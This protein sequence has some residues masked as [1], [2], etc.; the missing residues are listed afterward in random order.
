[1]NKKSLGS[2]FVQGFERRFYHGLIDK[3]E[4]ATLKNSKPI[5]FFPAFLSLFLV[6]SWFSVLS[7]DNTFTPSGGPS[8]N[9]IPLGVTS[10][11]LPA[12]TLSVH[13]SLL[14]E[15]NE[16]DYHSLFLLCIVAL[17]VLITSYLLIYFSV[18][19]LFGQNAGLLGSTL[20]HLTPSVQV[21]YW[22]SATFDFFPKVHLTGIFM[23]LV[24]SINA[25]RNP[26]KFSSV[27]QTFSES[28][29]IWHLCL[30]FT[31][32]SVYIRNSSVSLGIAILAFGYITQRISTKQLSTA[33]FIGIVFIALR[34]DAMGGFSFKSFAATSVT[35]A[36]LGDTKNLMSM[37]KSVIPINDGAIKNFVADP[38]YSINELILDK[39]YFSPP[40]SL[41]RIQ[42][43]NWLENSLIY[44]SLS[45]LGLNTSPSKSLFVAFILYFI[46]LSVLLLRHKAATIIGFVPL[47][48]C[49]LLLGLFSR[50]SPHQ[51]IQMQALLSLSLISLFFGRNS[52]DLS[53]ESA[54]S[55][56]TTRKLVFF[57]IA[58]ASLLAAFIAVSLFT[59]NNEIKSIAES[60][61]LS[62]ESSSRSI[63]VD[64][65]EVK[66]VDRFNALQIKV[67]D[68]ED[69][70]GSYVVLR[71][72]SLNILVP[73]DP[74]Q[75]KS[76]F[77]K[78]ERLKQ[79]SRGIIEF[80]IMDPTFVQ[81]EFR[82]V[83]APHMPTSFESKQE[84]NQK[85]DLSMTR[86]LLPETNVKKIEA[87]LILSRETD[88]PQELE[89]L[90]SVT[91]LRKVP[92]E[93]MTPET[94]CLKIVNTSSVVQ[95]RKYSSVDSFGY[96]TKF[97][98][99]GDWLCNLDSSP[100]SSAEIFVW[101][102]LLDN[103]ILNLNILVRQ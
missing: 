13:R 43:A 91:T 77:L 55:R 100:I 81:F 47:A 31:L 72:N 97:V 10:I 59:K 19:N 80:Q 75:K 9:R 38:R 26:L 61:A 50:F 90:C 37:N 92:T 35:I 83:N 103:P 67:R 5:R 73:T 30:I 34:V 20:F 42:I 11:N 18:R 74:N 64:F 102:N 71:N 66:K 63:K 40:E 93:A 79:I 15:F 101:Q 8:F 85:S 78:L 76:I 99:A 68:G 69:L 1:M 4:I 16:Q 84:I 36:G 46:C 62:I 12:F 25:T 54:W 95:I 58:T 70:D 2:A 44:H 65:S 57:Y 45:S 89:F 21:V 33:I 27:A 52:K 48:L 14:R 32:V 3:I 56:V 82:L 96:L 24:T 7:I 53:E 28:R 51:D 17:F 29:L 23:C 86:Y 94:L 41:L 98:N 60:K 6:T 39:I 87:Q 88:C 22:S 49:V